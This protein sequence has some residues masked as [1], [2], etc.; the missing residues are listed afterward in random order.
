MRPHAGIAGVLGGIAEPGFGTEFI[1]FGNGMECPQQFTRID[2]K[3]ANVALDVG[4]TYS[5]IYEGLARI[6]RLF[7]WS[8]KKR[9]PGRGQAFP[10]S[11][12]SSP[13][14][15]RA[16]RLSSYRHKRGKSQASLRG[17]AK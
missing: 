15:L 9:K 5:G 6:G 1:S 3:A 12:A 10:S 2:V 4:G 17:R 8:R 7:P 11:N 16:I 13:D 14:S